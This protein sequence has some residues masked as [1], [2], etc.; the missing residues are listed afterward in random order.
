M[1]DK[2]GNVTRL[3]H[4][5]IISAWLSHKVEDLGTGNLAGRFLPTCDVWWCEGKHVDIMRGL[6]RRKGDYPHARLPAS[7]YMTGILARMW[8]NPWIAEWI[9]LLK[10][11]AI[12]S[13]FFNHKMHTLYYLPFFKYDIYMT[14]I[15]WK[16]QNI[17][18][19]IQKQ[20]YVL[21]NA[22]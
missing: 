22:I 4:Y 11:A 20:W 16:I 17:L 14:K 19:S 7:Y 12:I 5:F 9:I 10:F 3:I 13:D 8:I 1:E 15:L 6:Y 2:N 18:H 21:G